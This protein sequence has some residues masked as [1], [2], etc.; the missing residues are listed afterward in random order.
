MESARIVITGVGAV[1]CLGLTVADMWSG[2]CAATSGIG[3]ITSFDPAKFPCKLAGEV[4]EYK[5]RDYVPKSLRK[6]TKLMSKNIEL[7]VIAA[8]EAL[9]DSG[10]VTKGIDSDNVSVDPTRMAINLGAGLIS[11][12]V[13]EIAPA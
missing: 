3:T 9:G 11:C 2:L 8:A 12:D 4:T 13:E 5:I 6:S 1:S 10:L 7:A